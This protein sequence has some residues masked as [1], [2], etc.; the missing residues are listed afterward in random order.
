MDNAKEIYEELERL[1]PVIAR[2]KVVH[3]PPAAPKT[4]FADMQ[5]EVL[6]KCQSQQTVP[7]F[8]FLF[9][10]AERLHLWWYSGIV[11]PVL[12]LAALALL[13]MAGL[14]WRQYWE[15]A[16]SMP[17]A[18]QLSEEEVLYYIEVNADNFDTQLLLSL[19][20]ANESMLHLTLGLD[21][22]RTQDLMDAILKSLDTENL[23]ELY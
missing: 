4:Y 5:A 3:E 9:N 7:R 16:P 21:E 10:C 22:P 8:K 20:P 15:V 1:S 23:K 19:L 2:L 17:L 13:V 11:R 6:R 18:A 12:A 14:W